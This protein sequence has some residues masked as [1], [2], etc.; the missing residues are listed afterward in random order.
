MLHFLNRNVFCNCACL[1]RKLWGRGALL[2]GA[3]N[4]L[5]FFGRWKNQNDKMDLLDLE[6]YGNPFGNPPEEPTPA[7]RELVQLG[8]AGRF[9]TFN[10]FWAL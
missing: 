1:A 3:T 2:S 9:L 10:I 7:G 6:K 5:S 4:D 8:T